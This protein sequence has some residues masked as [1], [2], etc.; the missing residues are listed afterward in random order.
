VRPEQ[1]ARGSE[2]VIGGV[3]RDAPDE[4]HR[5]CHRFYHHQ[6]WDGDVA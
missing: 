2:D 5:N 1:L 3:K 6:A 4:V